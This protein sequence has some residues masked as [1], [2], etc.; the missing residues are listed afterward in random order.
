MAQKKQDIDSDTE[1]IS[2]L[3]KPTKSSVEVE[4]KL[5]QILT[6]VLETLKG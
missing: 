6:A 5:K 1:L 3:M 4:I 2:K